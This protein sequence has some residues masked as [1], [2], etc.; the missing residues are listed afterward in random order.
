M[1]SSWST[2]APVS[3]LIAHLQGGPRCDT[4]VFR[5]ASPGISG[6]RHQLPQG[7]AGLTGEPGYHPGCV[8]AGEPAPARQVA[9][10]AAGL[11]VSRLLRV[12]QEEGLA[13]VIGSAGGWD[14]ALA[15][16]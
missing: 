16:R 8:V 4:I 14:G 7:G 10:G 11:S 9:A 15:I 12:R 1:V 2:S 5:F 6:S 13:G 3:W